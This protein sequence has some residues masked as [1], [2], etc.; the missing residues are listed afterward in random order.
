MILDS[1]IVIGYFNG[2]LD[3]RSSL[4]RFQEAGKV[5][6]ISQVTVVEALALKALLSSE[7]ED[8]KQFLRY[9]VVLP[10]TDDVCYAAAE[11]QRVN[12][13]TL[14]DSIIVASAKLNDLPLATRDKKL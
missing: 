10:L 12:N 14:A 1:N 13:L 9:F 8:I 11:L 5:M 2:D 6:F 3:I 4:N 7:I